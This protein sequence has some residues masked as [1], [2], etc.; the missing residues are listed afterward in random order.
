MSRQRLIVTTA[1]ALVAFLSGG[2][3]MQQGARR[4][5]SV[6]QRARL[7]DDVLAHVAEYY[8]DSLDERQ[9][10]RMAVDGLL[11]ELRDPYTVFLDQR[12]VRS[13]SELTTGNYGGLGLQIEVRDG[14][15]LVVAPLPET[16]A[17]RAGIVTGDRIVDVDGQSTVR[18]NQDQAVRSLRGQVGSRVTIRIER[19]G[20]TD[21]ITYELTRAQIHARSVRLAMLLANG[22]GYVELSTFSEQTARELAAAIDSLRGAGMRS[23]VLDLRWN[24]GGILDEGVAVADLFLDPGQEIVSTRGRAPGGTRRFADRA[25]QRYS[26]LPI[27]V[28]LNGAS[29]SASEI[30]AGALQDHDR[31]LVVGTTSFGKGLVQSVFPLSNDASLKLT[32][33]RWYTPS[34]RSIQRAPRSGEDR[35]P[36]EEVAASL[37]DSAVAAETYH[38]DRG[39]PLR[40]GGGIAPDVVVR[41]DSV[42]AAAARQLQQALG[43]RNVIRFT[44]ALAAFALDVRARRGVAGP[45][46]EVTPEMRAAFLALLAGRGV[47]LD[48]E[49][50]GATRAFI[51]Y[52]LGTQ[53]ARF[54]FGR[55]GEVRRLAGSDPVLSEAYRLAGRARHPSELFALV[56]PAATPT[57]AQRP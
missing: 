1:V 49:T 20:V 6:Y 42:L 21:L 19:P 15:I 28:L 38:S 54:A 13:L 53:V 50:L 2:W 4:D 56:A 43:G 57:S 44:D 31:A 52:Q 55:A 32:T 22:T 47:E 14:A 27:V 25:P 10:Y 3:F 7:F 5:E 9:L 41:P 35:D 16:P 23:L 8:V 18:W 30:V 26:D 11:R 29:A 24:P 48:Q 39:R 51:D 40:G 37:P 36:D 12:D 45:M 34:G 17:E 46:F 33:S